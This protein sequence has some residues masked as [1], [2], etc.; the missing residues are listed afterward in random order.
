LFIA[1]VT[2]FVVGLI[3]HPVQAQGL[4]PIESRLR[5]EFPTVALG[6]SATTFEPAD[7]ITNGRMVSGLRARFAPAA[8]AKGLSPIA[9]ANA[10]LAARDASAL[11]VL[12]P[13]FFSDEIV[14]EAGGQR[15]VLRA[16]GA[17]SVSAQPSNGKLIYEG[18]YDS[19]DAIEVPD[20]NRNEELLL[21]RDDRAPLVYDYE[22][23]EMTGV[24]GVV[25][26]DGAIRFMPPAHGVSASQ[27][28]S[29]RWESPTPSLEIERPWVVDASGKRSESAARWTL[30]EGAVP[31][32][33]RLT[34]DGG[35]IYPLVVDPSFTATGSMGSARLWHTA[36]LLPNGKVLIA[37]GATNGGPTPPRLY[38]PASGTF[39]AT[40]T[41][42]VR[43]LHTATLLRNGKVLFVG[44]A[45]SSGQLALSELYDSASGTFSPSGTLGTARRE[46]TATLLTNGKVLIAGGYSG[47]TLNSAELY[48]PASGTFSATGPMASPRSSHTATLLPDGKVL[49]TGGGT[50]SSAL[51][52]PA[53][54]TFSA[55]GP[56]AISRSSHSATLLPNGKVLIAGGTNLTSTELYD[57]A[58]G[59][60]SATG[61]LGTARYSHTATLLPSGKVLIAGGGNSSGG[62]QV[63]SAELYDPAA[64]T[65]SATASLGAARDRHTA[66]LLPN[67]KVLIAAGF[68]ANAGSVYLSSAELYDSAVGTFSATGSPSTT[69]QSHA[70]ALLPN[71]SVLMAGGSTLTSV[72]LYNPASGTFSGT[73][74][75]SVARTFPTATLLTNGKVLVV[76]GSDSGGSNNLNSAE[77]YDPASGTFSPTGSLSTVRRWHTATLL[78]NGKVLIA[79]GVSPGS[80]SAEL[81]DPVSGTFSAAGFLVTAR[82]AHTATLLPNG[83]VLLAGG[84]GGT[85][86]ELYDPA[87][88]TFSATGPLVTPRSFHTATLLPNGKVFIA[89]GFG[90][91]ASAVLYDPASGTFSATASLGTA[92]GLHTATLLANGKVLIAGGSNGGPALPSA[93]LYDPATGTTSATGPMT[94]GR[95]QHTATL[96]A[97]AKVLMAGYTSS[98]ELYDVGDGYLDARRPVIS[99][100]PTSII[101]PAVIALTGSN[102]EGDSEASSSGTNN[103][104]TNYPILQLMRIDNE[105]MSFLSGANWTATTLNSIPPF[106]L[107]GGHYRA[108]IFTN[109]IPSL[110]TNI[111]IL[112]PTITDTAP[113]TCLPTAGGD[114]VTLTGTNLLNGTVTVNGNPAT[115][116]STTGTTVVFTTPAGTAGSVANVVVT[117]TGG[118]AP[119]SYTYSA[120]TPTI[121]PSPSSV[122]ANATGRSASGP[123]GATT[124]AWSISNGTITSATNIQTITYTAGASGNV[125]LTLVVTNAAG[126]SAM[127]TVN[128]TINANPATPTITPTPASVCASSTGNSAAGP[129]GATT[130][131]WSIVNGTISSATNIQTITYTAG[132]SGTV[133]L[134][135]VVT[136]GSGCSATNTTNVTINAKPS[137]PTITP[138]P[139]SVC[140]SSTGNSASGPAG[141]TTYAWSI[142]NGTITS[143]TNIQTITYTAGSSGTVG[144][145]LT[146][147]NASGCSATN[148]SNVTINA[149]P[150]TPAI[151][152]TPASVCASSSGN[153]AAGPAGATTYAWSIVNGTISSA[154]NIQ[155]I[156]YTAGASGTV[157]L[158]LVVT[159]AS[160]CSATNTSNV[161]INP[162]PNATITTPASAVSGSTG[163]IAS[164][165]NAGVG[166]T[167]VWGITNGSITAGAGTNSITYT[168]GGAGTLVLNVT[169]TNSA[170][171]G[172]TK[173]ANVNVPVTITTIVPNSGTITGGSAVTISG[174]GFGAGATV[175]IGG[176]AATNVIVVNST[177]ITARTP[178]HALGAVNA[179]VTNT[180]ATSGTLVAGYTYKAQQFDPNNDGTLT[181]SDIFYLVNYLFLGGPAPSGAAGLLSGDANGDGTVDPLD[182]FYLV[183]YLFLGGPRPNVLPDIPRLATLAVGADVPH[184]TGGISLGTPF[185]REGHHVVPVIVTAAEGSIAPQAMSLRVHLDGIVSNATIRRAGVAKDLNIA[186]ETDHRAGN[187]LSYLV[188]FG[189]LALGST[190]SAV[191]AEIELD[192]GDSA[193]VLRI[194][195]QL[196]MLG[197]QAG[198]TKATVSNGI[199]EVSGTTIE[200]G[201]EP[202]PRTPRNAN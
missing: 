99:G 5:R 118:T 52:D 183:N 79:G 14:A 186:F 67:G 75:L 156:A 54:G 46:H 109:A 51:Y 113:A 127:N 42:G 152:P 82:S 169:V 116:T 101:Q 166:A 190:R 84:T 103:S 21:L 87:T 90:G 168:A 1:I 53:S 111:L 129:G 40:G 134:T 164:V 25:L 133:D 189:S 98:A 144:L 153:S 160:G 77:L 97:N 145:T 78:P 106:G 102:F 178:A 194:D 146:V 39:S 30:G 180:N 161:T 91:V 107:T 138:T 58:S 187:D 16:V 136:N 24:A 199:L 140:A 128:V 66:T 3:A 4:H 69:R 20:S 131:A 202:E 200:S 47:S 7:A 104:A 105:Q 31:R 124:Y 41:T 184:I 193:V 143:A 172:D 117:T 201:R 171:C 36:T 76:G 72:E 89:G 6:T 81:Y 38:D 12:Y 35:L 50:N 120:S 192:A 150:A 170:G 60:F 34:L 197:D 10:Q 27:I 100:T 59:T 142:S 158:T 32:T 196:T 9:A 151:T 139:A 165:A 159:N 149:N 141:A 63:A 55:T 17:R 125:G 123:A 62:G 57:P 191:V 44:G 94:S 19:V 126:C 33:I 96:L 13:R 29:G 157:G 174:T 80:T 122:C 48:D 71:G 185:L 73:G 15:V 188:S 147:T 135:L 110:S 74:P 181:S 198:M 162:N 43:Y 64:G 155:T 114:S 108:T 179:T 49:I 61:P 23:V 132:A 86:A 18:T 56:M 163:N 176:A 45:G 177:K 195:P 173:S 167:Y 26:H 115:V 37:G 22:I 70:A 93:E 182:I 95:Y 175:T 130:Y 11:R 154:T 28:A 137:T 85:S 68:D 92:R 2:I 112:G 88:G 65:F 148:T 121:T 83:K 119:T 8:A